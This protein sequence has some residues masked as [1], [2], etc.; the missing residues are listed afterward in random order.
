MVGVDAAPGW[1]TGRI[2]QIGCFSFRQ[3]NRMEFGRAIWTHRYFQPELVRFATL[4]DNDFHPGRGVPA[5]N[6]PVNVEHR[7]TRTIKPLARISQIE[8]L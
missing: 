6:P 2:Q 7:R 3:F 8:R 5:H 4:A 1:Q